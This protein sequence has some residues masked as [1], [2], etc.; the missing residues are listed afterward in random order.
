MT[1][2]TD[3]SEK[4]EEGIFKMPILGVEVEEGSFMQM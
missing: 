1:K 3:C 4:L 2:A